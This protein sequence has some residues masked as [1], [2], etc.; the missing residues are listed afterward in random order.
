M[1]RAS[2]RTTADHGTTSAGGS[3]RATPARRSR[4]ARGT[5][6]SDDEPGDRNG[7]RAQ[8]GAHVADAA[9]ILSG[10]GPHARP[11]ELGE[12]V[13]EPGILSIQ[14]RSRSSPRP[15][16]YSGAALRR[17]TAASIFSTS[18]QGTRT[19]RRFGERREQPPEPPPPAPDRRPDED[20]LDRGSPGQTELEVVDVAAAAAV[21]VDELVVEQPDGEVD[22]SVIRSL[23]SSDHQG[24]RGQRDDQ[25]DHEVDQP[26]DV[27]EPPVCVSPM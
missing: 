14:G 10:F 1:P 19:V 11:E 16:P 4:G 26:E 2:A 20:R 27:R 15:S 6:P 9:E 23:R 24:D 7:A 17:C 25:D 18:V 5:R 21:A 22:R 3:G 13:H 12:A 8:L